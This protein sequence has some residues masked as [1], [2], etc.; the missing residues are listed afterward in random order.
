MKAPSGAFA[1]GGAATFPGNSGT[2][3]SIITAYNYC[4]IYYEVTIA[5]E[6]YEET[7]IEL[8][9]YFSSDTG[10]TYPLKSK[11]SALDK[12]RQS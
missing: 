4:T 1:Y 11:M 10:V 7:N 6:T 9:F 8:S 5:G 3:S 2:C 12:I